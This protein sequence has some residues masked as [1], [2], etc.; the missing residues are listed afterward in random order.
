MI[1]EDRIDGE[2]GPQRQ[3]EQQVERGSDIEPQHGTPR[4]HRPEQRGAEDDDETDDGIREIVMSEAEGRPIAEEEA[5][6]G[7]IEQRARPEIDGRKED[8]SA[9]GYEKGATEPEDSPVHLEFAR[10]MRRRISAA[11]SA[12][13]SG[14][15]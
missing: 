4:D 13:S 15:A 9:A 12:V 7:A 8:E 5:R 2:A 11:A 14:G 3:R 6:A 1:L 10:S